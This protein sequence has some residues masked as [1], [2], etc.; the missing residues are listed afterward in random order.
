MCLFDINN[1]DI[2]QYLGGEVTVD[3][4]GTLHTD[5]TVY[6]WVLSVSIIPWINYVKLQK[7]TE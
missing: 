5:C 7:A 6:Y 4:I 2:D 1:W 3:M